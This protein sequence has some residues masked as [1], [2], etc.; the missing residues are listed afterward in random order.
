MWEAVKVKGI[1]SKRK[2]KIE[3][4]EEMMMRAVSWMLQPENFIWYSL[5][6]LFG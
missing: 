4:E 5:Q 2:S 1:L 3:E 6:L